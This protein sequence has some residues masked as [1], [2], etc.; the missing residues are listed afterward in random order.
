[1]KENIQMIRFATLALLFASPAVADGH[2]SEEAALGMANFKQ[3]QAC[4]MVIDADGNKLAGRGKVGPNLFGVIGREAGAIEG[5]R[6][7][8]ALVAAGEAGIVWD[9]ATLSAFLL[10]PKGNIQELLDDPKAR[11]KMVLKLRADRKN[12]LSVEEVAASIAT[13]LK[14][15]APSEG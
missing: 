15:L 2:L 8:K 5:F 14:E 3:C 12:N 7:S 10:D 11:T 13:Y 1:M 4:H 9:E 6:Y